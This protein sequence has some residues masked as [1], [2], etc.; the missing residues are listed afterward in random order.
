MNKICEYSLKVLQITDF[1]SD[2]TLREHTVPTYSDYKLY[3]IHIHIHYK[4]YKKQ[5]LTQVY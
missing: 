5:V 3:I 2:V 1:R 4:T